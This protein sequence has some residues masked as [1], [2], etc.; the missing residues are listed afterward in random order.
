MDETDGELTN[1]N[2]VRMLGEVG[3]D[4]DMDPVPIGRAK[5]RIFGDEV[6]DNGDE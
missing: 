1:G 3:L 5:S 6:G 2:M 4:I